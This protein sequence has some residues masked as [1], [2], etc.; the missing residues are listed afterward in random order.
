[1]VNGLL[2]KNPARL[3]TERTFP[4]VM[5]PTDG[6][7]LPRYTGHIGLLFIPS[8]R[9]LKRPVRPQGALFLQEYNRQ[10]PG[11]AVTKQRYRPDRP[12]HLSDL[13]QARE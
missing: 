12:L 11:L 5:Y 8:V 7:A 9:I 1:M 3:S 4:F 10:R 13:L 2:T 6:T